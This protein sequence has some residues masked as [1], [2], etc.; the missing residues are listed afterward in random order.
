CIEWRN[1]HDSAVAHH[2]ELADL[3]AFL[4]RR[5]QGT[6]IGDGCRW[7]VVG[8]LGHEEIDRAFPHEADLRLLATVDRSMGNDVA[9]REDRY[10]LEPTCSPGDEFSRFFGAFCHRTQAVQYGDQ[11]PPAGRGRDDGAV[12][13]GLRMA[14]LQPINA[15]SHL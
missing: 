12:A 10:L 5:N 7:A 11:P 6:A 2:V 13:G 9:R 3:S 14:R 4:D 15:D 8:A 1:L